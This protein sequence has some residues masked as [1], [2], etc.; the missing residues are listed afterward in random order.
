MT[1]MRFVKCCLLESG[2]LSTANLNKSIES[3]FL[4]LP[5]L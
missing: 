4:F 3:T 2:L 1:I 5:Y